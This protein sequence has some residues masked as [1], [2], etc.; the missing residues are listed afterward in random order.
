[1]ISTKEMC[2]QRIYVQRKK[3]EEVKYKKY[4]RIRAVV[5]HPNK[6]QVVGYIVKRPDLLLMFKRKD[7]FVAADHVTAIEGGWGILPGP[8]LF[9]DAACE[10]LGIDFDDC[11]IW[12]G[13]KVVNED[14]TE[15]GTIASVFFDDETLK[16]DRIDLSDGGLAR[17]LLGEAAITRSDIVGFKGDA[18]VV[19]R[20]IE[21]VADT[22]GVAAQAGEAWAKTKHQASVKAEEAGKAVNEGAYKAGQ[23]IAEG[24]EKAGKAVSEGAEKAGKAVDKGAYNVGEAVGTARKKMNDAFDAH[25]AKKE[26]AEAEG[27]KTGVDKGAYALGQQLGRASHMFQDFKDE[28]DKASRGN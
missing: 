20:K 27:K 18:I 23:A 19:S 26:A 22:G 24:G 2:K 1:M 11:I 9:D 7:R 8:D 12:D 10:R 3:K 21:E 5:F 15:L 4:G 6:A 13:M 16:V 25:E 14:G 17:K 28:Y